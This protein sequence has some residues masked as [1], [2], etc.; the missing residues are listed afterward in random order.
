M[1]QRFGGAFAP[2]ISQAHLTG[3]TILI[4]AV[5]DATKRAA[6]QRLLSCVTH[7]YNLPESDPTQGKMHPCGVGTIIP[8]D[9]TVKNAL[10]QHI[11]SGPEIKIYEAVAESI[12]HNTHKDLRNAAHHL[13]WHVKELALGREPIT[14]DKVVGDQ[15]TI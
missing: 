7:W 4:D 8:L 12:N 5:A 6:L 9:S 11:P 13:L 1:I 2:P 3:Y 10:A 15:S 14:L